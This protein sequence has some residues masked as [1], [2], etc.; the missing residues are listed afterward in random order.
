MPDRTPTGKAQN[1]TRSPKEVMAEDLGN[2]LQS[3]MNARPQV[4]QLSDQD[5][6]EQDQKAKDQ[7]GPDIWFVLREQ[8]QSAYSEL[9]MF[10]IPRSR[11]GQLPALPTGT[12]ADV[13]N[14]DLSIATRKLVLAN[15]KV[16]ELGQALAKRDEEL[17]QLRSQVMNNPAPDKPKD[18]DHDLLLSI[19]RFVSGKISNDVDAWSEGDFIDSLRVHFEVFDRLEDLQQQRNKEEADSISIENQAEKFESYFEG[20]VILENQIMH[21]KEKITSYEK[22]RDGLCQ[23]LDY[24]ASALTAIVKT[25]GN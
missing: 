3:L 19:A 7:Y 14:S 25:A 15:R 9:L 18:D 8:E 24:Q 20:K 4:L 13:S 2:T 21:L 5:Y 22:L 12:P 23:A 11:A 16:E 6:A 17:R 1:Q 10:R